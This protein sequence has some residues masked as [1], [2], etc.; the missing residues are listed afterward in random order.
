VSDSSDIAVGAHFLSDVMFAGV[1]IALLV[2]VLHGPFWRWK[3]TAI[4]EQ[5]AEQRVGDTLR[6]LAMTG[7]AATR[8]L[9]G[10]MRGVMVRI[11]W[12][13]PRPLQATQTMA[14][15]AGHTLQQ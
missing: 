10:F 14:P 1:F 3:S 5:A 12:K 8:G 15:S 6:N 7:K 11:F 2:W 4:S 13:Q 9:T